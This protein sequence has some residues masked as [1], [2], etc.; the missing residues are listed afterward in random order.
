MDLD[1]YRGAAETFLSE[2]T[3]EYYRHYAGFKDD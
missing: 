1:A 2:L 3:S